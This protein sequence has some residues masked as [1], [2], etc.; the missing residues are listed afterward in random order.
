MRDAK[1]ENAI[2]VNGKYLANLGEIR[3]ILHIIMT[4]NIWLNMY[5]KPL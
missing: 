4:I 2:T 5:F 1:E 3:A